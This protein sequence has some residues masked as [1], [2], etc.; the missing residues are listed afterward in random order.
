MTINELIDELQD[1][2]SIKGNVNVKVWNKD[3]LNYS[4]V[5]SVDLIIGCND[6]VAIG[7]VQEF[8]EEEKYD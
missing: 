1:L 4:N 5:T 2:R 8:S 3:I 6:S 7:F